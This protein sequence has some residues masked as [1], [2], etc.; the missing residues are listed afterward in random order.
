MHVRVARTSSVPSRVASVG[1]RC[2]PSGLGDHSS[3]R[4][5]RPSVGSR[6]ERPP[7][8][9]WSATMLETLYAINLPVHIA[10]GATALLS[11]FAPLATRK[12]GTWHR[13]LG[14]VFVGAM[15]LVVVTGA[16]IAATWAFAPLTVRPPSGTLEPEELAHYIAR[17]RTYALFFG[18]LGVFVASSVWNGIVSLRRAR[19]APSWV[20]TVDLG[21]AWVSLVLSAALLYVGGTRFE[22]LLFGFAVL[23][24]V[25]SVSDLR[26][27]RRAHPPR[28]EWIVRHLQAML[29]GAT[30]AV[31]AFVVQAVGR[32]L[33]ESGFGGLMLV[34]WAVPVV[35]GTWVSHRWTRRVRG[36]TA[37]RYTR[38]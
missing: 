10:A 18:F 14:W 27:F 31:T 25:S 30:A 16:F 32:M 29:G 15:A 28:V 5:A 33:V 7:A 38:G 9:C 11:V 35:L 21:V 23:G 19:G 17:V 22:P 13:R 36:D 4:W 6:F 34:A 2:R 24:V 20:R 26:F 37:R 12:G 8:S 3:A 1:C